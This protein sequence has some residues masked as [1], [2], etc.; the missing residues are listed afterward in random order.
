MNN[1]QSERQHAHGMLIHLGFMYPPNF[2]ETLEI[3]RERKKYANQHSIDSVLSRSGRK[4]MRGIVVCAKAGLTDSQAFEILKARGFTKKY[5]TQDAVSRTTFQRYIKIVRDD[6]GIPRK[7]KSDLIIEFFKAGFDEAAICK[8][9][10]CKIT[11]TRTVLQEA[12]LTAKIYGN[13]STKILPHQHLKIAK[14]KG[15]E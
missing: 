5:K 7:C 6:L 2:D 13:K 9:V 10:N 4:L 12:G 3:D 15:V 8:K 1:T 14:R 11:W